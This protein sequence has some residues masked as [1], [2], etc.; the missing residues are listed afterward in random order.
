VRRALVVLLLAACEGP[1]EP[2]AWQLAQD[3][4][5]SV[6]ALPPRIRAGEHASLEGLRAHADGATTVEAPSV[7]NAPH[8]PLFAAVNFILDHW[9][10]IAPDEAGLADAR[11]QLGLAADAPILVEL[12]VYFGPLSGTHFTTHKQLWLGDS[13]ANPELPAIRVDAQPPG[14][15]IA[16]ARDRDITLAADADDVS[17][18]TSCGRLRDAS[19]PAAILVSGAACTGELAVVVRD[20]QGGTVWHVWPLT[21]E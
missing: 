17:W 6:R 15:T 9:E 8:S 3:R 16:I 4:V 7:L 1:V 10:V 13:A 12:D 21:V 2:E 19:E 5:V 18:F 11:T 14:D 20:G